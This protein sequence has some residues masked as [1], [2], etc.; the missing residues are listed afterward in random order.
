[1]R[2]AFPGIYEICWCRKTATTNCSLPR[3]FSVS[4]GPLD[5]ILRVSPNPEPR[6]PVRGSGLKVGIF[7]IPGVLAG[8]MDFVG[9][10]TSRAVRRT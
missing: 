10:F 9:G 1:M 4:A 6:S 7:R 2:P 5:P 8:A 3:D